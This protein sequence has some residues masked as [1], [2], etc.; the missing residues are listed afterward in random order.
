MTVL[1]GE[2]CKC[3]FY[4]VVIKGF[5]FFKQHDLSLREAVID[6]KIVRSLLIFFMELLV[7]QNVEL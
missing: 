7:V 1:Y 2:L 6:N 3:R 4:N 5:F